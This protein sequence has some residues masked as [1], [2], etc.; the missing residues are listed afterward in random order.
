MG[1]STFYGCVRIISN[2]L[3][4]TPFGVY[5]ELESGGSEREKIHPLYYALGIRSNRNMSPVIAKRTMIMNCLVFGFAI[6]RIDRNVKRQTVS[7]YPYPS[8]IVNVYQDE[9]TGFYFFQVTDNGKLLTF[10]EDDV[11][12]LKDLSFDGTKGVSLINWQSKTIKLDLLTKE[13]A[14]KYYENGTFIGGFL[15]TPLE[16]KNKEAAVEY[17]RRIIESLEG[18]NGGAGFAVLGPGIK[19]HPV[20]RSPVE[21]EMMAL[22]NKSDKDIAKMFGV[23]LSLIGDTEKQT[24]WGTGVEQM[25]IGLV[26]SVLIPLAT[27]IEEEFNYKCFRLDEIQKGYYTKFNFRALLRGDSAAYG[28]YMT[29]MIGVG[30]YSPD[31]ARAFDEMAP[32]EGGFGSR[33]FTQGANVPLDRIDDIIDKKDGAGQKI[34]PAGV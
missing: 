14:S 15:E 24:S 13:F 20:S 9:R 29:K 8:D 12:F 10:S 18:Q 16:A 31:E 22:F 27:Q 4:S 25:F 2:L 28:E 17:K 6:A 21:S 23:P 26:R 34:P 7:Y 11:I 19:W 5:K 1:I 3:S 32:I 30:V 33:H